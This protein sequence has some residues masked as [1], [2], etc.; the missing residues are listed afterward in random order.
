M[1]NRP[2]AA[3]ELE[4]LNRRLHIFGVRPELRP[5]QIQDK[6][7]PLGFEGVI[8]MIPPGRW[9]GTLTMR[10]EEDANRLCERYGVQQ[11]RRI[12]IGNIKRFVNKPGEEGGLRCFRCD[13][14][15]H[16]RRECREPRY[17]RPEP[18]EQHHER[19]RESQALHGRANS[20]WQAIAREAERKR[21]D[22]AREPHLQAARTFQQQ[23]WRLHDDETE[24]NALY[25]PRRMQQ[26]GATLTQQQVSLMREMVASQI[27]EQ[28]H[29]IVRS[30]EGQVQR[31]T[32]EVDARLRAH[33][34]AIQSIQEAQE[35]TA[36]EVQGIA[37]LLGRMAKHLKVPDFCEGS[38]AGGGGSQ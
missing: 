11:G 17:N 2:S 27:R 7:T 26:Q 4:D 37:A 28:S 12:Y 3:S 31:Y 5:Q 36:S 10:D 21:V 13:R 33:D 18:F 9:W 22:H 29:E 16:L 35:T 24:Y 38:R 19:E 32:H 30:M 14:S 6:L 25:R 15:G 23:M 1:L 34:T 20:H 8:V